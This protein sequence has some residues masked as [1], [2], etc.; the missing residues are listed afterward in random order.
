MAVVIAG[1]EAFMIS[2]QGEQPIPASMREQA[3]DSSPTCR[4][5]CSASARSPAS[6]P[7]RPVRARAG[8]PRRRLAITFKGR[9][10]TL[11][12][13]PQSGRVLS[14][15]FRGAGPDGVP[16]DV[17]HTYADFRPAGGLTLPFA[18]STRP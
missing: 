12:I 11:G 15:S 13:D 14:A 16:G 10:T 17:V 8:T 18:Q 5:C 9:T 3:E 7:W 4:S 2:P 1:T 6:T